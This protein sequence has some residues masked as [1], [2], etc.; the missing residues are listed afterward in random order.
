M[1][2]LPRDI[3]VIGRYEDNITDSRGWR[4][5]VR[6]KKD[7]RHFDAYYTHKGLSASML[8][9]PVLGMTNHWEVYAVMILYAFSII[10]RYMPN[11]VGEDFT[12]GSRPL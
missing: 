9:K 5:F 8:L 7:E 11:P 2:E 3:I 1:G 6:H 12:W 4:V 10:V